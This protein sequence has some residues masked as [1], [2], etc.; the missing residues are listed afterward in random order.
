MPMGVERF[1]K[2]SSWSLFDIKLPE[3]RR[4]RALYLTRAASALPG[5]RGNLSAGTGEP[6]CLAT[7]YSRYHSRSQR[8]AAPMSILVT[9]GCGR[10]LRAKDEAAGRKFRCP[11]CGAIVTVRHPDD[12]QHVKNEAFSLPAEAPDRPTLA[13]GPASAATSDDAVARPPSRPDAS[14]APRHRTSSSPRRRRSARRTESERPDFS[15]A[16]HPSIIAGLLM[17]L[18]ATLWFFLG[19]AYGR[20]F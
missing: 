10:S 13:R 19:L 17:M 3:R 16:V 11:A 1:R 5:V 4:T 15:I 6:Y 8:R 14:P 7:E 18:G 9:C 20:I 2:R 12:N